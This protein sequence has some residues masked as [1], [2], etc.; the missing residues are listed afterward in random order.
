MQWSKIKTRMKMLICPELQDRVDFHV[1]R[2][3]AAPDQVGR[4]WVTIDGEEFLD[5]SYYRR[6]MAVWKEQQSLLTKL[7]EVD[8][9]QYLK[10]HQ[11]ASDKADA[12]YIFNDGFF[13]NAILVYPGISILEVLVS[14]NPL[15]RAFGIIDRRLGKRTFEKIHLSDNEHPLVHAFYK[16]RSEVFGMNW[17]SEEVLERCTA[18]DEGKI[19]ERD[20]DSVLR[21]AYRKVK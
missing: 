12:D 10:V 7:P 1:T 2:F 14:P 20:A 5:C 4:A 15:I 18:F 17:K 16:L 11:I 13:R 8:R 3:H 6:H 9:E 19:T 21:D